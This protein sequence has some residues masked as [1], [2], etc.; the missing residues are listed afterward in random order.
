MGVLPPGDTDGSRR[1]SQMHQS[2][3]NQRNLF[4]LVSERAGV[5]GRGR[6]QPCGWDGVGSVSAAA[7]VCFG[8]FVV[9]FSSSG[10]GLQDM[11]GK[12]KGLK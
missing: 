11:K 2:Q 8:F 9:F 1:A 10:R 4:P 5:G 3:V 6:W 12:H 7:P